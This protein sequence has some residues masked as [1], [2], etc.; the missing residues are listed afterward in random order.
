MDEFFA[1][2]EKLDH[3]EL[4][5]KPL[6]IGGD[7]KGR[8]VVSTASYEARPFGCHS[9][10]P[11]SVA[12]RLCPQAI[13]LPV[14]GERYGQKSDEVFAVMSRFTP[15]IEPL[16]ID[17]A[18]LDLTG[19]ERLLGPVERTAAEIKAAI[20][21]DTGLTASVGL[22]P[23]KFLA[24]LGS[25]LHKPDGLTI[26][27]PQ[28]MQATLDPLAVRKL[29]G[30]G[31]ATAA[32]LDRIGVKTIA[33]LRQ[34]ALK[35]LDAMFGQSGEH[36][37]RLARGLDDRDVTP[38]SQAKSIGQETTF[39][40]DLADR[41]AVLA[42]L[43]GQAEQVARRCRKGGLSA[44]TVTVKIRY[45]D[46]QTITRG[47]TLPAPT[48]VTEEIWSAA[49]ELFTR[50]AAAAFKPVRLIGVTASSLG[51]SGVGQQMLFDDPARRKQGRIDQAVDQIVKRFG[52]GSIGR[53]PG[54]EEE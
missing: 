24:K 50:W 45:G 33:E 46:F 29:W 26:I 28:N 39:A 35:D 6:L 11:M 37:Y 22:A 36:F 34:V 19:T 15:A 48:D 17:E 12:M 5:G 41:E 49:R 9:A 47:V 40:R 42:V 23:N 7:P 1:A 43:L 30:V 38:D 32:A 10:M 54:E 25:D 16:S 8:G 3:P 51:R 2:V 4:R 52:Q 44:R 18:F 53:G 27:T 20:K 31:E 13:V 14:R 21:R